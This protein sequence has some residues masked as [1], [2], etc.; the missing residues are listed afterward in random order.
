MEWLET[1]FIQPIPQKEVESNASNKNDDIKA[2]EKTENDAGSSVRIVQTDAETPSDSRTIQTDVTIIVQEKEFPA[3]REI[4][5][6]ESQYFAK[7]FSNKKATRV[8]LSGVDPNSFYT[9]LKYI[10]QK[11][12]DLTPTNASHIFALSTNVN[13]FYIQCIKRF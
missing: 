8:T 12:I 6:R 10:Y 7:Y 3:H 11:K 1:N 5:M 4:L 2:E 9:I 13:I